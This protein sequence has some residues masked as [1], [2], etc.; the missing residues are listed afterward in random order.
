[1]QTLYKTQDSVFIQAIIPRQ[2]KDV[3]TML[4]GRSTKLDGTHFPPKP[5]DPNGRK[6]M[7]TMLMKSDI[8]VYNGQSTKLDGG[9]SPPKPLYRNGRSVN[10]MVHAWV[11]QK[12][13]KRDILRVFTMSLFEIIQGDYR[14]MTRNR[15]RL[16]KRLKAILTPPTKYSLILIKCFLSF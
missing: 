11:A 8:V 10:G 7:T 14:L 6:D 1:M 3:M 2:P 5:L 9:Y 13:R 4:I 16:F 12:T 15:K